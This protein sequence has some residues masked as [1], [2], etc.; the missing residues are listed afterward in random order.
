MI[1][2]SVM[3]GSWRIG[4]MIPAPSGLLTLKLMTSASETTLAS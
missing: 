2:R 4:L 3:V 1:T